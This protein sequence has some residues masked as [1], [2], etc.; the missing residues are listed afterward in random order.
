MHEWTADADV[1]LVLGCVLLGVVMTWAWQLWHRPPPPPPPQWVVRIP[2]RYYGEGM[3][4]VYDSSV[5]TP[6][7][8]P[9]ISVTHG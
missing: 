4:I 9:D 8:E 6:T 2:V 3:T 1:W 7:V 5:T